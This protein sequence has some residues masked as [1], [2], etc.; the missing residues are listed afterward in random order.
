MYKMM[1]GNCFI[2][3]H[4]LHIELETY[5]TLSRVTVLS[6]TRIPGAVNAGYCVL[7]IRGCLMFGRVTEIM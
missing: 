7:V 6:V 5:E 2:T 3:G 4:K 1:L